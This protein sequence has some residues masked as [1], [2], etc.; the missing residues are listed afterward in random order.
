LSKQIGINP[1]TPE[2]APG[3]AGLGDHDLG[4]ERTP[5]LE[6][7]P[8][9]DG[10]MLAGG[11]VQSG[12]LVEVTMIELFPERLERRGKVGVIDQPAELRITFTGDGD[13]DPKTVAVETAT[14][15]VVG[16]TREEM[17]GFE[18]EGFAEFDFHGAAIVPNRSR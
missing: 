9:P 13:L 16:K 3:G 10:D 14:F 17:S 1:S 8:D 11:V 18:L 15:M 5:G 7:V 2:D 6:S 4:Q 12:N